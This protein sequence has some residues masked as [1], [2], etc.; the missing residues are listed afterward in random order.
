[1]DRSDVPPFRQIVAENTA[2]IRSTLQ[3]LGV[4]ASELDDVTQAVLCG[5]ARGLDA[6]DPAL[7]ADPPN[8]LRGWL[9]GICERQAA[10]AR[11]RAARLGVELLR[12][13]TNP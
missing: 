12:P 8:A 11:R 4:H 6:F 7:S 5:V 10:S 1:M 13:L 9:V 3:R 2:F